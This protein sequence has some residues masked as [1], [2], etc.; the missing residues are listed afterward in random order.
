MESNDPVDDIEL[1]LVDTVEVGVDIIQESV[2]L[3]KRKRIL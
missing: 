2:E 1:V 3:L